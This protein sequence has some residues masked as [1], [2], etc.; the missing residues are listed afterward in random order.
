M[1][2]VTF[3]LIVL[4]IFDIDEQSQLITRDA[5]WRAALTSEYYVLGN[6]IGSIIDN[7]LV[8]S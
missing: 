6:G 7:L 3:H 5:F 2:L 8:F 4:P 1:L